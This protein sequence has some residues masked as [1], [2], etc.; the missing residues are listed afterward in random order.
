[1]PTAAIP[2]QQI[3]VH[4]T[5]P[6]RTDPDWWTGP[7]YRVH[8]TGWLDLPDGTQVP[9]TDWYAVPDGYLQPGAGVFVDTAGQVSLR[10]GVPA[11][12]GGVLTLRADMFGLYF[13]GPTGT[14]QISLTLSRVLAP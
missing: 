11:P 7:A 6:S 13:T 3:V 4:S 9:P 5:P 2:L 14:R 8:R 10:P 12:S 1:M